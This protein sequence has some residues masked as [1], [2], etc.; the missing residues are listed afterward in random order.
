MEWYDW[1]LS[2]AVL[3]WLAAAAL[4]R[5]AGIKVGTAWTWIPMLLAVIYRII[6]GRA[7]MVVTAAA[8]VLLLSER[9]HLKQKLLEGIIL[10]A[11][12][13]VVGWLMFTTEITAGMGIVGV[14]IF[15]IG[16]EMHMI[17]GAD[18]MT[19][20]T[21][22]IVWPG[23]EFLMAYLVAGLIWALVLRIREGGW[24]KTHAAPG[25]AVIAS[26][27]ALYILWRVLTALQVI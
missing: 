17:D 25:M 21:C 9:R 5:R 18:A 7:V 27:A 6:S 10:A 15:W 16:W 3:G 1:V 24:L 12:I 19:L 23:I 14:I 2:I 4:G 8:I 11:G 20:I 13:L 22:Q 26:G